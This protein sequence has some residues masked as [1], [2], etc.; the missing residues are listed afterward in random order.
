[1]MANQI[2][3]HHLHK[4]KYDGDSDMLM[5]E[6]QWKNYSKLQQKWTMLMKI[7]VTIYPYFVA[8][9]MAPKPYHQMSCDENFHHQHV[10]FFFF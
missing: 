9:N 1:M 2:I 8:E 4:I 10:F 5:Q 6:N 3:C 7:F